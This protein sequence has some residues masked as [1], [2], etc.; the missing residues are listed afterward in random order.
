MRDG[1][2][3]EHKMAHGIVRDFLV[4][5]PGNVYTHH[6]C[7]RRAKSAVDALG[8]WFSRAM[9]TRTTWT[10]ET[11]MNRYELLREVA[12]RT[13]GEAAAF[14]AKADQLEAEE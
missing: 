9:R 6:D 11:E 13:R 3:V 12:G 14:L 1:R 7:M 10:A 8:R 4:G 2:I 5:G